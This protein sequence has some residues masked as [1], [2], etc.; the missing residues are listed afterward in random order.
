MRSF[1]CSCGTE[2]QH[3][4]IADG[5]SYLGM[6]RTNGRPFIT[7]IEIHVTAL[8]EMGLYGQVFHQ[9]L[10]SCSVIAVF[11]STNTASSVG[12]PPIIS[13]RRAVSCGSCGIDQAALVL[14]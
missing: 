14:S 5:H 4:N 2:R 6:T 11:M 3:L 13:S 10:Q 12:S 1:G 7:L 8:R 9:R